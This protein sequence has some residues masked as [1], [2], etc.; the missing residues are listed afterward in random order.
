[1]SWKDCLC[2]CISP[3][4]FPQFRIRLYRLFLLLIILRLT[5]LKYLNHVDSCTSSE[6]TKR[7]IIPQQLR[8]APGAE[9][10]GLSCH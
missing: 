8:G 6:N 1:M 9:A 5:G 7:N 3:T 4:Y 2:F 10:L